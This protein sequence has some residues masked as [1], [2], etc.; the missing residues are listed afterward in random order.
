LD[1]K[2]KQKFSKTFQSSSSETN[3]HLDGHRF[4]NSFPSVLTLSHMHPVNALTICF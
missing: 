2:I 1:N 4:Y 3:S